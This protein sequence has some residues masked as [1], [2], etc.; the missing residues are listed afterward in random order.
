MFSKIDIFGVKKIPLQYFVL[1][2]FL[3][4]YIIPLFFITIPPGNDTAMHGY[5]TRLIINNNG[6]PHSYRPILPVDYFGSYSAG[7]HV[8]TALVGGVSIIWLRDAINFISIIVYP[9]TLLGFVFLLMRFFSE[10]TAIYTALIFFCIN[11]T[12]EGA[13]GWGG[14]STVLSFGFCLFSIGFIIYAIQN[15]LPKALYCSAFSIAAIPLIHAVPAITFVYISIPGYLMLMYHY[16]HQFKWIVLNSFIL[17]VSILFLLFPFIV[18]F[19]NENSPELLLLIKHWQNEMMGNKLTNNFWNNLLVT[20]GQIKYRTGDMLT[21]LSGISLA[22]LFYFKKYT[23]IIHIAIFIL[24]IFLLIF[25]Y[26][27]WVLPF[28]ELLY[29]DRVVYFMIVCVAFFFGYF[30]NAIESRIDIP[31]ILKGKF[32]FYFLIVSVCICI[33]IG[34]VF[35]NYISCLRDNKINCNKST[36]AAFDWINT[37]TEHDALFIA[38]YANAGMWIPTF[39]N[40]AT[41]GTHL[42]FIHLVKHISDT[43]N[44]TNSPRYFFITKRD[45]NSRSEISGKI[46]NRAKLFANEAVEIYQ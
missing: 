33:S 3:L 4:L 45:I 30:L 9:L 32:N 40:R 5:I 44:S 12:I 25:N 22:F 28:S 16:R 23:K 46:K 38:S 10:K 41:I 17:V 37:H 26:G 36:M 11:T 20:T 31:G 8:L 13:I 43:L 27:Y 24:F 34:K 42:H 39:T 19:K 6:L 1:L 2:I 18:H 29:P 14:N 21:I 7:Y 35:T 15:K